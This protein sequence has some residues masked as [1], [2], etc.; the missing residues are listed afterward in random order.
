MNLSKEHKYWKV[1]NRLFQ[2]ACIL[3]PISVA[4]I[5]IAFGGTLVESALIAF[6]FLL[7]WFFLN[8]L[9][10]MNDT[11]D[12]PNWENPAESGMLLKS[13]I[14]FSVILASVFFSMYFVIGIWQ[15]MFVLFVFGVFSQNYACHVLFQNTQN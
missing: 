3:L 13:M 14:L 5:A 7:S 2:F 12:D 11:I 1:G 10:T 8:K 9:G 15:L 4:Q 6:P